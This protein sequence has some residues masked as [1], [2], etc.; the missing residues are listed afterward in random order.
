MSQQGM[1]NQ[2]KT[3]LGQFIYICRTTE[4]ENENDY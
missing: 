2:Q 3:E 1:N 4:A